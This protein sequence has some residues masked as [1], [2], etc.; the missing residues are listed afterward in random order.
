MLVLDRGVPQEAPTRRCWAGVALSSGAGHGPVRR[1]RTIGE[2]IA[3][4]PGSVVVADVLP[5]GWVWLLRRPAAVLVAHGGQL[6]NAAIA[7]RERRVPALTGSVGLDAL[8]D[9][10]AV[11]VDAKAGRARRL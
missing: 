1:V 5:A 7:L 9:G 8:R 4:P 10:D 2:A 3:A 11:E 6:C